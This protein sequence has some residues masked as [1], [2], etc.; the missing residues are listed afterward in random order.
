VGPSLG[1]D[2][3][4]AGVV[5][6]LIGTIGVVVFMLVGYGFFGLIA[7]IALAANLLMLVGLLSA[8]GATLTLPG[9]AGLLL[10]L[11]MAVDSNVLV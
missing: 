7:N 10:T 11:G 1:S 3:I 6:T 8:L 2:S 9:I 5:A 4:R